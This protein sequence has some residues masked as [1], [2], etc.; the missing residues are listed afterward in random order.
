MLT[1]TEEAVSTGK[2]IGSG[3]FTRCYELASDP[4]RVVI[5]TVDP[6]KEAYSDI[7]IDPPGDHFPQLEWIAHGL[8]I[9]PRYERVTAPKRQLTPEDYAAYKAA[10][11]LLPGA[12]FG[13]KHKWF[14]DAVYEIS[15]QLIIQGHDD[16]GCAL[17]RGMDSVMNYGHDISMEISPRN[18]A[19]DKQGRLILLDVFYDVE[20]MHGKDNRARLKK[21][22]RWLMDEGC[23]RRHKTTYY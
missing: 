11:R 19:V 4:S 6:L 15:T 16:I 5:I 7:S 2:L 9:A 12:L 10:R 20:E 13:G 23:L 8:Y 14:S 1:P 21:R 3:A 17:Q 18:I 22:K